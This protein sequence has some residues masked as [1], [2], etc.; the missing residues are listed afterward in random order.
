ML[1][2]GC[3]RHSG[4]LTIT[5]CPLP[6]VAMLAV[7]R[8]YWTERLVGRTVL[9]HGTSRAQVAGEEEGRTRGVTQ[10]VQ[11]EVF[12]ELSLN[13]NPNLDMYHR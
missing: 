3:N 9:L 6:F 1:N 12:L 4:L 10:T 13:L 11:L 8:A 2:T 5:T 7:P